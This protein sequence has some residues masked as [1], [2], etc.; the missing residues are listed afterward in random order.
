ML[1]NSRR[2]TRGASGSAACDAAATK[3][4]HCRVYS[5]GRDYS[6]GF[7]SLAMSSAV[8]GGYL[9]ATTAAMNCFLS[10]PSALARR[11]AIVCS[12]LAFFSSACSFAVAARCCFAVGGRTLGAL[13]EDSVVAG[14]LVRGIRWN[15]TVQPR[16]KTAPA[17]RKSWC[18]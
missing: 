2:V 14:V 1:R 10:I 11:S 4:V 9:P 15:Y 12:F 17:H 5:V 3:G 16:D 18:V 13:D 8:I 7:G 6:V